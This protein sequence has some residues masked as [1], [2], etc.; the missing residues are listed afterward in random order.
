[1]SESKHVS[2][3]V[4]V[5]VLHSFASSILFTL[6]F[7]LC[8]RCDRSVQ[9]DTDTDVVSVGMTCQMN[10]GGEGRLGESTMPLHFLTGT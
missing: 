4:L 6:P 5:F 1:M 3:G 7:G 2:A 9:R 10:E 8:Q